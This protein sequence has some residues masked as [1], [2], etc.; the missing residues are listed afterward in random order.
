MVGGVRKW[1][2][3]FR[4]V[5]ALLATFFKIPGETL[6]L[7]LTIRTDVQALKIVL[8]SSRPFLESRK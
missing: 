6:H 3:Q 8:I 1:L 4:G 2:V 5:R 7:T